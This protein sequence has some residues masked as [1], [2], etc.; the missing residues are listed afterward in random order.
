MSYRSVRQEMQWQFNQ[1]LGRHN[2]W[3]VNR[4][5]FN[6]SCQ[7]CQWQKKAYS[8]DSGPTAST[9][10]GGTDKHEIRI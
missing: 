9:P 4:G 1:Q 10:S 3:H 5:I 7:L 8:E 2:R 6:P